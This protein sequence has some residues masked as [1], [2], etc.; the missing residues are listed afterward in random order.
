MSQTETSDNDRRL[1]EARQ[2]W[3]RAAAAFDQEPD[4]GLRD[5]QV[6]HA[7]AEFL[8][9]W[10]PAAKTSILDTGCGTGSLSVVLAGLGHAVTGI[11]LSPGMI[12]AAQTKAN[13][14]GH[15]IEFRVMDAAAPLFAPQT[16]DAI[17]CRH[18]LWTLPEPAQVLQRWVSLLKPGGR[19]VL[20]EGFWS[21]GGG[22][23]APEILAALPA[24]VHLI[25]IQNLSDRPEYWG[26]QV[27]DERYAIIADL[28]L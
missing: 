19:L 11:D 9:T 10:L 27:A 2:F 12:T 1:Q 15:A 25:S 6:L 17:L 14:L 5:P 16:F 18:L 26:K 28:S 8:K 13:A 3:D 4:H 21:A 20:I 7:W 22:L 23:H 24:P